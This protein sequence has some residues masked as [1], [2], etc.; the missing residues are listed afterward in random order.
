MN[1]TDWFEGNGTVH[2][3]TLTYLPTGPIQVFWNGLIQNP[4]NYS[5]VGQTVTT[6]FVPEGGPNPDTVA[7][8]YAYGSGAVTPNRPMPLPPVN[9]RP[10]HIINPIPPPP[11]FVYPTSTNNELE[12]LG[13]KRFLQ[14]VVVGVTAMDPTKVFP[15]WQTEPPNQPG[16]TENWA[17]IG[18]VNRDREPFAAVLHRTSDTDFNSSTDTV[19]RN[20]ILQILCSY[21]G[22]DAQA[23]SELFTMGLSLEQNREVMFLNGFGLISV[24]ESINV[25]ALI[26]ERWVPGFD[27]A[28]RVRRQQVYTYPVP[29]LRYANVELFFDDPD[30]EV[31]ASVT[32][33]YGSVPPYEP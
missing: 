19:V 24:D 15:R 33:G 25:P 8:G 9:G 4:S 16:I 32:S 23:N 31:N 5:M 17:A 11:G 30:M 21:Y 1:Y 12:D 18:E 10:S 2:S 26:K 3:F 28:F 27:V 14:Q 20:Q 22:P 6:T 7:I 13:L 29:N